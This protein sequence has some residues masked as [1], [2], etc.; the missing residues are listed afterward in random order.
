[1]YI[2]LEED[3]SMSLS[4]IA[5]K[6]FGSAELEGNVYFQLASVEEKPKLSPHDAQQETIR[7]QF[8]D[9]LSSNEEKFLALKSAFNRIQSSSNGLQHIAN[10]SIFFQNNE[11]FFKE[12]K[13]EIDK[14]PLIL[15]VYK[16]FNNNFNIIKQC[17]NDLDL[18]LSSSPRL[19]DAQLQLGYKKLRSEYESFKQSKEL[20]WKEYNKYHNMVSAVCEHYKQFEYTP[21][22]MTY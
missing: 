2:N 21:P 12:L 8:K 1:M 7:Q 9:I 10:T 16:E 4:R 19:Q 13:D 20:T 17:M 6:L 3:H 5:R 22:T 15:D 18:Y 14:K 11:K